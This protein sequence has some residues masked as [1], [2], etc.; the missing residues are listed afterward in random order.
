MP[1]SYTAALPTDI[2]IDTAVLYCDLVTPS[3]MV[4]F[5]GT[6]GGLTFTKNIDMRSVPFDGASGETAGLHRKTDGVPTITGTVLL[7]GPANLPSLEPGSTSET[8]GSGTGAVQTVTPLRY[9]TMLDASTD[10]H[11]WE[12]LWK[13]GNGGT[14]KVIFPVGLA[15]ID[16]IGAQDNNE[17]EAPITV[18]AVNDPDDILGTD[19]T[20]APYFYEITGPDIDDTYYGT[21]S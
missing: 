5:G 2:L 14:F 6:R 7:F 18:K 19:E 11:R 1:T 15:S 4:K 12:C 3:S 8:V 13:R 16:S 17:G 20:K 9:R 21:G 10:Y